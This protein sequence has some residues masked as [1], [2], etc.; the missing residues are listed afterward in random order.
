MA[1]WDFAG[2]FEAVAR[3]FPDRVAL[4]HGD[5][6]TTWSE[7]DA[8]ASALAG[9]LGAAGL[10]AGDAVAQYL[11]NGPE[12]IEAFY[13]ASKAAL[14]PMNTNFRYVDDELVQIWTDADA[15]AVVFAAEFRDRVV[16]VRERVPGVRAWIEVG[17][18]ADV[19]GWITPYSAALAHPPR[20]HGGGSADSLIL[21]YT[22]GTTGHPKGVMW[23]QADILSLLN[24]QNPAPLPDHGDT[25]AIERHLRENSREMRALTAAPLMHGAGLFYA[26]AA[27]SAGT[28]VVTLTGERFSA[29]ELLDTVER[30]RI[31]SL[32]IVGDAFARPL[33]AA[34]DA[35]PG[36]WDL[37]GL[38]FVFSS[39]V[40]WSSEVKA[41]LLVHLPRARLLDGLGSSEASAVASTLSTAGNVADTASF[42]PS[43]RAAILL[44]DGTLA[45]PG[46][47]RTG[48]LAV[49]GW[50][51]VG[52]LNDP[53][54]SAQTFVEAA[55]RRWSVPGD[56]ARLE[57]DGTV[58]LLGR[59]SSVVNT[60]G[61]KV[62][63]EEVEEVLKKHPA[64]ADAAVVGVPDDRLGKK[65]VAL[66]EVAGE[67]PAAEDILAHAR[68]M[69][70][71][72]KVPR[73]IGFVDTVGRGANGKLDHRSL[74]ALAEKKW[75]NA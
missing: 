46:D 42:R 53:E 74:A 25:A 64:V 27:L 50:I 34:L 57:A 1:D 68:S 72:Y 40:M 15:K 73:E 38:R 14:A 4:V 16:R 2:V 6:R 22:G 49:T 61:E 19:P 17:G 48:R 20:P 32:A 67:E 26:I 29:E 24:S 30:E 28:T 35:E 33:L 69:L 59:G 11:R 66:V 70:A 9:A 58:R 10:R 45:Q 5:R 13:A 8:N 43:D 41:G 39:G 51:P 55:G 62:F 36:R 21:V 7:L 65:V 75:S 12:Y 56:L 71:G 31:K 18:G 44:D 63:A 37:S 54:K 47:G 23:R 52:Y 3:V 60:G